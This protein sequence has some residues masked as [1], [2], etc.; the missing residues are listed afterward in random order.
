MEYIS[1]NNKLYEVQFDILKYEQVE[2]TEL[3]E[4]W[5]FVHNKANQ[6]WLWLAIDHDTGSILI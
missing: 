4:M 2:E 3:D 1:R 6:R 5:S